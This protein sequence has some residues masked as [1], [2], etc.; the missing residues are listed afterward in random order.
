MNLNNVTVDKPSLH[1]SK[2]NHKKISKIINE[3]SKYNFN[4]KKSIFKK[5]PPIFEVTWQDFL[6][7]YI[8]WWHS[9]FSVCKSYGIIRSSSIF[10]KKLYKIFKLKQIFS[11]WIHIIFGPILLFLVIFLSPLLAVSADTYF[12]FLKEFNFNNFGDWFNQWLVIIVE[13]FFNSDAW[14][15]LLLIII[16][17]SSFNISSLITYYIYY[18]KNDDYI[19]LIFLDN[20][21]KMKL[22]NFSK[23]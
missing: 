15:T 6:P 22:T 14:W 12:N 13:P 1:W 7:I 17:G 11:V 23:K 8:G 19:R 9:L 4:L 3:N 18:N 5:L 21:L 16:F 2:K 20:E 10:N